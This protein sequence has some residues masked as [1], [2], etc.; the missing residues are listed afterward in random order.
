NVAKQVAPPCWT[1]D[2]CENGQWQCDPVTCTSDQC[3]DGYFTET[4]MCCQT[5]PNG[6]NCKFTD[7][8]IPINRT[9]SVGGVLCA[10]V[11]SEDGSGL[12]MA[13]CI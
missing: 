6:E 7:V 10:C 3:V 9:V 13:K 11:E 2:R 12:L 5:C 1:C 4:N 8:I